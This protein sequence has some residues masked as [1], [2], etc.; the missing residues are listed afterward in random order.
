MGNT[1]TKPKAALA[2]AD[3][4]KP[5]EQVQSESNTGYASDLRPDLL[6]TVPPISAAT[7]RR[8]KAI[9]DYFAGRDA[10]ERARERF[11]YERD[12]ARYNRRHDAVACAV[13]CKHQFSKCRSGCDGSALYNAD[14][15]DADKCPERGCAR[16]QYSSESEILARQLAARN[17]S[18]STTRNGSMYTGAQQPVRG[19]DA[20]ARRPV[21]SVAV[22]QSV[23]QANNAGLSLKPESNQTR[24]ALAEAQK[25]QELEANKLGPVDE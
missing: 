17:K 4:N 6:G 3:P 15:F 1:A 22:E 12:M 2:A 20:I 18:L 25:R 7:K 9:P 19:K 8:A 10:L 23:S 16:A 14:L 13:A 11:Q 5:V 24:L 21:A